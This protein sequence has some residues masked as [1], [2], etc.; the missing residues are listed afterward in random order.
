MGGTAG[1]R[2]STGGTFGACYSIGLVKAQE[3]NCSLLK[4]M[5]HGHLVSVKAQEVHLGLGQNT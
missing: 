3:N 2:Q 4:Q 5:R 1:I